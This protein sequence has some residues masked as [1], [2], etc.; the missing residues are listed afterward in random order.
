MSTSYKGR[1][2]LGKKGGA[3][4]GGNKRKNL[5]PHPL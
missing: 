2:F 4:N 3:E 5:K 1:K